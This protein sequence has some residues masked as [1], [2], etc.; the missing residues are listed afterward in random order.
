MTAPAFDS[1]ITL[2][3][4]RRWSI[5]VTIRH[6]GDR[7]ADRA[8]RACTWPG[9]RSRRRLGTRS[10]QARHGALPLLSRPLCGADPPASGDSNP[11]LAL[12][13]RTDLQRR[14]CFLIFK[15]DRSAIWLAGRA[16]SRSIPQ[17]P[18]LR[19]P[20]PHL[21]DALLAGNLSGELLARRFCS[22][23]TADSNCSSSW[24]SSCLTAF[25]KSAGRTWRE[26]TSLRGV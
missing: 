16:R 2:S 4:G 7:G 26:G 24:S 6:V 5:A 10:P 23:M 18:S 22:A 14:G 19:R 17:P 15:A 9:A 3:P 12:D 21:F 20:G 13:C 11:S 1:S 8:A 25:G